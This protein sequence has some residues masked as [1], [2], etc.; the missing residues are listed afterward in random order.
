MTTSRR[1]REIV[2]AEHTYEGEGFGVF[3]PFP[4]ARLSM[5]DPFLLLDEMEPKDHAPNQAIG[6]SD[7]PHRGFETVTYMLE[8]AFEHADSQG[9]HGT[10]RAGGVQWMTAGAGIVHREQPAEDIRRDGGRTHG[11]QLWVNLPASD[12]MI[13]PAYQGFEPSEIPTVTSDGVTRRVIAG[14]LSG[15]RGV[16]DTHSPIVYAHI[17]IEP[18]ATFEADLPADSN[19]GLYVFDGRAAL[20]PTEQPVVA[21]ELVIYD[22][23]GGRISATAIERV[24]ALLLAGRPLNEPVA[25]YGPFVMNTRQQL[26]EAFD[27]YQSGRMGG[28]AATHAR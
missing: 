26:I 9:N 10:I 17:T 22:R 2:P 20:G 8:G 19:V 27:D 25:R 13:A 6:T 24:E 23:A 14:E 7:H 1:I 11:F 15:L 16:A 4:Q 28:I 18:G 21:R 12:K 3:R 5:L